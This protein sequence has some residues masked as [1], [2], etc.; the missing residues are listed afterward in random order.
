MARLRLTTCALLLLLSTPVFAGSTVENVR[1]WSENDK[2]RV[3]LDLSRS[4]DHSIFTLRDPSRLVIDLKDSR[5]G[6][7]FSG[8]PKGTG[9][10]REIRSGVRADGQLR[11]VLDLNTSV[12]SRTFT[13]E[14]IAVGRIR[15][16]R[17][18]S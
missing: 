9:L 16:R 14:P 17:E 15:P 12:R 11:V 2:T 7:A 18:R 10:I 13:A 5:L 3:V 4:V 1:I 6:K 8:M